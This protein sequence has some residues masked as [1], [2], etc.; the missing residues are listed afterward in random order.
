MNFIYS[1]TKKV[2]IDE[3]LGLHKEIRYIIVKSKAVYEIS[4]SIINVFFFSGHW[5]TEG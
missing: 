5:Q 3:P 4:L 1:R 2:V